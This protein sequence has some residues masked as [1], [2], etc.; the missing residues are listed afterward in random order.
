MQYNGAKLSKTDRKANISSEKLETARRLVENEGVSIRAAATA[1]SLNRSTLARYLSSKQVGYEKC[2]SA[3]QILTK[4]QEKE[5]AD[6][7]RALDNRF[8]GLSTDQLKRL[9]YDYSNV[10]GI[11]MPDSWTRDKHAGKLI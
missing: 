4:A 11:R 3:R 6:H 10:N 5:L 9:A 8:Y 7:V 1:Q 2:S